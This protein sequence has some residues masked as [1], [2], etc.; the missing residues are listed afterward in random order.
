MKNKLKIMLSICAVLLGVV[1][2]V[3][4]TFAYQYLPHPVG[5]MLIITSVL[6]FLLSLVLAIA[7]DY[8]TGYY[9]CRHC[10][11][12]FTPTLSAY[13]WGMHTITTRRLKCP[14]CGKKSFCKHKL[15]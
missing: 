2:L 11:H 5:L 12:R 4:S 6:I 7:V 3:E 13:I 10:S 8:S 14:K 15:D 9:E 1:V